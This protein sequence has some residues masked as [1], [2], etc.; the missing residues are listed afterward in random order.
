MPANLA[1]LAP[2]LDDAINALAPADR[3]AIILRFFEQ[4]DFRSVG[5]ALNSGEDAARMRV[6]RRVLPGW[7]RRERAF[8]DWYAGEVVGAVR[9]G[10][11]AGPDADEA[12]RLPEAVTGFRSVRHPK[13]D[14]ARLRFRE[15]M[16]GR[17]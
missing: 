5:S 2:I 12:L 15:L 9:D 6:A 7:H 3:T 13:E 10:W 14:R 17:R 4:R 8:R 1:H 11:L 16:E